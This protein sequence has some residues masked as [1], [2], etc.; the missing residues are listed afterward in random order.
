MLKLVPEIEGFQI[1]HPS[2]GQVMGQRSTSGM[3]CAQTMLNNLTA[4][5]R[6]RARVAMYSL[7]F[8]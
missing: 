7:L 5:A 2:H 1:V 4:F 6:L 3:S 8:S